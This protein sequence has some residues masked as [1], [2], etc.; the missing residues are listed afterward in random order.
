MGRFPRYDVM[1]A[2]L[3]KVLFACIHVFSEN[4]DLMLTKTVGNGK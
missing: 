3:L 2:T 1:L 4:G